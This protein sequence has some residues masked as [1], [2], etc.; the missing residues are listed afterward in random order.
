MRATKFVGQPIS[1]VDVAV[2]PLGL[3]MPE[4]NTNGALGL[5]VGAVMSLLDVVVIAAFA[6]LIVKHINAIT[7]KMVMPN[8]V[9]LEPCK[10]SC[11][12]V[13]S[14]INPLLFS[15]TQYNK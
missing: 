3:M 6:L 7:V 15:I 10:V 5:V 13:S 11:F 14:T 4:Y 9:F 8:R 1:I 12:I 2:A